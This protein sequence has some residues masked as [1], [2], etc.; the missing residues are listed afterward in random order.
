[1]IDLASS[2]YT[3]WHHRGL[4]QMNLEEWDKA[5]TD[6][7]KIVDSWPNGPGGW[8]LRSV[9]YAQLNKPDKALADLR[10]AIATGFTDIATLQSDPQL[11]PL[12]GNNDFE[13]LLADLERHTN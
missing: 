8:Y 2:M 9:V 3:N 12:R 4:A 7:T 1:A 11:D 6:F 5:A 13:K 10:R